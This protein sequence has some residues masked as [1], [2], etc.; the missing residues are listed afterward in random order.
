MS[1]YIAGMAMTRVGRREE[2]LPD[3]M[4]EAGRGALGRRPGAAG[5][6]RR[7]RDE[8]RG[9]RRRGHFASHVGTHLGLARVP[10]LRAETATSSGA[11]ALFAAYATVAAG[12]HRSVL[13]VGGEKMTHLPTP[14]V[15]E[16]I[17]R[18]IDPYEKGLHVN[19]PL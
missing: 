11:A 12:F 19:Y 17:G 8:P 2:S 13:V 6:P 1:V 7:G 10:S 5:R 16:L 14:R 4:A 18:S 15:S 9:V 3:L